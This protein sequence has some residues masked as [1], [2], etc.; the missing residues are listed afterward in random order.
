MV[1]VKFLPHEKEVQI[2]PGSSL[3][4]AAI[5][6][7]IALESN[8]GGKGTCGKCRMKILSGSREKPTVTENDHF[9]GEE[10]ASGWAL[11][12]Q[13]LAQEDMI[14]EVHTQ[15]DALGRKASL[16]AQSPAALLNPSVNKV[17]LKI[18]PPTATDQT[19]DF[20]RL[21]RY[22][23][24]LEIRANWKVLTYLP[25]VLR[26][27]DYQFTAVL[28]GNHLVAIE[29][30]DTCGHQF[31]LA[32]DIGTTT[33]AGSLLDLIS[34]KTIAASAVTNPQNI[35]GADVISRIN[36][37][38]EGPENLKQL[39]EKVMGAINCLIAEL[40]AEDN[41]LHSEIYA[42][43]IVGNTT[44]SH[45]F[46]GI[47]PS[48]LAPAP[49][50]PVFAQSLDVRA[51][52]LGMKIHPAGRVAVLPNIAGYVG[53][54]TVGVMLATQIDRRKGLCL[55]V[56]LGTNGEI[57]LAHEG[58]VLTCSTAAGPAFEGAHI[59]Q[60]MRAA[61]G[62]IESVHIGAGVKLEVIG[63]VSP[64]G[65][66][67]SGLID[68]VAEM[69]RA[70]ILDPDGLFRPSDSN[71]ANLDPLLRERI[72]RSKNGCEFVLAPHAFSGING[73][74]VISQ[75]DIQELVLAKAAIYA[76]IQV[77]LKEMGVTERAITEI[78]LAGAFGN[79]IKKES[80]LAIGLLPR[81]ALNKIH[82]VGNAAN[83]GAKLALLSQKEQA[84]ALSLARRAEH[85]E[86]SNRP[87]FTEEFL[88]ALSFP[89]LEPSF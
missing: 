5:A 73:D 4:T 38:S 41:L 34:G 83:E 58:R 69:L 23:P 1:T 74:I 35:F 51:E 33:I 50:V 56:D 21:L 86:L 85:V 84:R 24:G 29:P 9:S 70:G 6:A 78:L 65:I 28:A 53:S 7:D 61:E 13:C 89:A 39:Q 15:K 14:V 17:F 8:C 16:H 80:A 75:A 87:D 77:L 30:G 55:I 48:F 72:R 66:C 12:C 76:G 82:S 26:N 45:L 10:L 67:G 52:Q 2:P 59:R 27:A 31:G 11:A 19:A 71:T 43:V 88:N 64:R 25:R 42:A 44:M 40:I 54:D 63:N 37:A 60:G 32:L 81:I 46:L 62:A 68:A 36:Y 49:F 20:E 47:D 57:V 79:Y 18:A 22:L 3:F